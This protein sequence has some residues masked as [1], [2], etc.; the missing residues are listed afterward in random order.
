MPKVFISYSHDSDT[1]REW[2]LDLSNR[3]RE[4]GID[5]EIDQYD[6]APDQGWPVWMLRK[7]QDANYVLLVCT[8][9]YRKRFE[10]RE[11]VG[12]GL[13]VTWEGML[14]QNQLYRN[15]SRS[16]KFIPIILQ[17][18]DVAYVP[19]AAYQYSH[20]DFSKP[21]TFEMLY[22]H[23][24][25]ELGADKPPLGKPH[26]QRTIHSD[27]LPTVEGKLFGRK[28]ELALLDEALLDADTHVVQFVASGGTGKTKL[29]RHWLDDNHDKIEAL[30]AW[31]F[32]SQGSSEDKQ[33]SATPFFIQALKSLRADKAISDFNTEE[34]KGEY[35]ANLLR[36]RRCLLVLDG[37]EPLQQVGCGMRGELKDRAIRK[38][39][40]CLVG[41]HSSLCIITTRLPVHELKGR[42]R[43]VQ[44]DLQNLAPEDGIAL[45]RSFTEP[46]PV[47]GR[48]EDMLAAVEEYGRHA[49][50]LHLLGNALA[51]YLD[52]DVRKRDTL[53]ELIGDYDDTELHAFKVMQAYEQWLE[54]TV[55]LKLLY[56]LGLFDHPVGQEVL[57]VLWEA[58]I[59]ELTEGVEKK[60]WLVARRDLLGKFQIMSRHEGWGNLF[61]CHPLVR[62]YFGRQLKENEGDVWRQAH[63]VL[64]EYYKG[65]PEK[66]CGKYL[67]DTL[68]EMQPLFRAVAHGC[69]AGYMSE[70]FHEIYFMRIERGTKIYLKNKPT[71]RL[72]LLSLFF[73]VTWSQVS[74]KLDTAT[75]SVI[76]EWSGMELWRLGRLYEAIPLFKSR[77]KFGY[78]YQ[79][80]DIIV[81][82]TTN[83]I[84]IY[85]CLGLLNESMILANAFD[86]YL[87]GIKYETDFKKITALCSKAETFHKLGKYKDAQV[88]FEAASEIQANRKGKDKP[89]ELLSFHGF[90]YCQLLIDIGQYEKA[91][92]L[93]RS[94]ISIASNHK[95]HNDVCLGAICAGAILMRVPYGN[96]R[97]AIEQLDYA[98]ATFRILDQSYDWWPYALIYRVEYFRC[99]CNY[100][101]ATAD[102][103]EVYEIAKS[104]SM[105]L[106]LTDYHLEM[107]RLIL[108][109]EADSAQYNDATPD[110]KQRALPIEIADPDEPGILTLEGHIQAA[111]KLIQDTG[112]YRR[113][114]ELAEL[115]QQAGISC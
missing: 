21:R 115:K 27:A 15:A 87:E 17:S 81:G 45:L 72:Q 77:L 31:S 12:K 24:R 90:Q 60:A 96:L 111:N 58:E 54:G 18:T 2:V 41:D 1:H 101:A 75:N 9:T 48:D 49:L 11:E 38:M 44:H 8:E 7:M 104:S 52:G 37:L 113:D 71:E 43:V 67:P 6:P 105:R 63:T 20:Y 80:D 39:L 13:G 29:L 94:M 32:Y 82:I 16:Q 76:A 64:Y 99:N 97:A 28:D 10:Q 92:G 55:E 5:C 108:A 57:E 69:L 65:L 103:L 56:L 66:L 30:I 114:T 14:V 23:L 46:Y 110:R 68:E 42:R 74:S 84:E 102:L 107:S 47:H 3:L 98:I 40:R 61:D 53:G 79:N 78:K 19:D 4:G 88:L 86:S 106:H 91:Y 83:L 95:S 36:E 70:S 34:E 35:I 26:F 112:Y 62:E 51:T 89:K 25:G 33:I 59:P 109:I 93:S 100:E 50:A 22:K 73:E 85:N